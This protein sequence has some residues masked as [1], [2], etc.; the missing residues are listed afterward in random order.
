MTLHDRYPPDCDDHDRE[1]REIGKNQPSRKLWKRTCSGL[2]ITR[3]NQ[4]SWVTSAINSHDHMLLKPNIMPSIAIDPSGEMWKKRFELLCGFT[5]SM[6]LSWSLVIFLSFPRIH[7]DHCDDLH[8]DCNI[9]QISPQEWN[10]KWYLY[11]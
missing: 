10:E 2:Y 3:M 6:P 8:R 9:D 7:W 4:V 1:R 5:M 11:T